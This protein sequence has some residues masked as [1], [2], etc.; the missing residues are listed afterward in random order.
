MKISYKKIL[1]L[2][3]GLFFIILMAVGIWQ[4][5]KI[6]PSNILAPTSSGDIVQS[7]TSNIEK[8]GLTLVEIPVVLG[9]SIQASISGIRVIFGVEKDIPSQVRALQVV[10][11]K[12][13]INKLPKEI[14][15][16]YNKVIIKY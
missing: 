2:I 7:V 16:R 4:K 10:L 6:F 15:L 12:L 13:T 3:L 11:G 14:D 8:T 1:I 5:D 9:D